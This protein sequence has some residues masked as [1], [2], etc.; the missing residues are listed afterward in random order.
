M[1]EIDIYVRMG[2]SGL[3]NIIMLIGKNKYEV[4]KMKFWFEDELK[5]KK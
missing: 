4:C 2:K 1:I 5:K 3:N